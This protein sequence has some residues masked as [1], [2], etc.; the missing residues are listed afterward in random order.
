LR[1]ILV[2][3]GLVGHGSWSHRQGRLRCMPT[4]AAAQGSLSA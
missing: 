3:E 4:L 1:A 2:V